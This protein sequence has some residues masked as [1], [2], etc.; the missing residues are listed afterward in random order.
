MCLSSENYEGGGVK[1]SFYI[2]GRKVEKQIVSLEKRFTKNNLYI[3]AS[4]LQCRTG[5]V[6][7]NPD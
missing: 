1:T 5:L 3:I 2:M 6:W 4:P 7:K